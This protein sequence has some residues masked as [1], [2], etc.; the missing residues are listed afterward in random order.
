MTVTQQLITIAV[1]AIGTML[2]SF[3]PFIIF[4]GGKPTPKYIQY[5]GNMSKYLTY[6][7]FE[8]YMKSRK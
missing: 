3:L 5:I 1:V 7:Q 2:T 6:H 8:I 4:P